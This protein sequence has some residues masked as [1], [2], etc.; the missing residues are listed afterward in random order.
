M[1]HL[2]RGVADGAFRLVDDALERQIVIGLV[3]H[4]QIGHGVAD[5]HALIETRAA[6]NPIGNP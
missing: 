6:D 4:P 5:F 1:Q 3:D 2:H